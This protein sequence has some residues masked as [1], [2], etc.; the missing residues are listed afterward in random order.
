MF[1]QMIQTSL[2]RC[3]NRQVQQIFMQSSFFQGRRWHHLMKKFLC[4]SAASSL[5]PAEC[6]G[7]KIAQN[8]ARHKPNRCSFHT[9]SRLL[10]AFLL[11][12]RTPIS[13]CI[14]TL[15]YAILPVIAL[16]ST[17]SFFACGESVWA[18]P[19][20]NMEEARTKDVAIIGTQ[21]VWSSNCR[22]GNDFTA[23][24]IDQVSRTKEVPCSG[25]GRVGSIYWRVCA[26]L[27]SQI[28]SGHVWDNQLGQG[29]I[30][31]QTDISVSSTVIQGA[32]KQ[33]MHFLTSYVFFGLMTHLVAISFR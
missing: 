27:A 16:P 5:P 4:W 3:R 29:S 31:R 24:D 26:F 9:L 7:G 1:G 22:Q 20:V 32:C 19:S 18:N 28:T 23:S 2:H 14:G 17:A 15:S 13:F 11:A 6:Y 33:P 30:H 12:H 8:L 21:N 25:L 10:E